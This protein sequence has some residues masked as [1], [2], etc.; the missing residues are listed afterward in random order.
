MTTTSSNIVE[1]FFLNTIVE[2]SEMRIDVVHKTVFQNF[3]RIP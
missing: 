3:L 2:A 1:F